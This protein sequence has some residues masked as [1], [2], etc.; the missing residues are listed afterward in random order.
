MVLEGQIT[1]EV[2]I[3]VIISVLVPWSMNKL[4]EPSVTPFRVT[5]H[6]EV[7]KK[8]ASTSIGN[9]T[10]TIAASGYDPEV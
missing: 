9:F 8:S 10:C 6:P 4:T 7:V 1:L 5:V 3:P 2:Q